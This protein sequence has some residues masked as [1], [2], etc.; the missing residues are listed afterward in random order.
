MFCLVELIYLRSEKKNFFLKKIEKNRFFD[1]KTSKAY[2]FAGKFLFSE[3][4]S[5]VDRGDR[6]LQCNRELFLI[7]FFLKKKKTFCFFLFFST[8]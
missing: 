2:N 6:N 4:F 3:I 1:R 8:V 5:S 7:F